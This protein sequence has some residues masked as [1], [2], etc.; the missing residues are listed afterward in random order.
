MLL[1]S[2]NANPV[3]DTP[4]AYPNE[5]LAILMPAPLISTKG[6]FLIEVIG[7]TFYTFFNICNKYNKTAGTTSGVIAGWG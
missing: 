5:M 2:A 6:A 1:Y 4:T 7:T 3:L